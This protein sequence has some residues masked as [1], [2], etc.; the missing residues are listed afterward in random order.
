MVPQE[1]L[2]AILRS[3]HRTF[4]RRRMLEAMSLGAA[5]VLPSLLGALVLG[6]LTGPRRVTG[7]LVLAVAAVGIVL[8][9]VRAARYARRHHLSFGAFVLQIEER[10]GLRR[11]ELF[12]ALHLGRTASTL[13]DP[14]AREVAGEVL[15]IGS[16][17][18]QRIDYRVLARVRGVQRS[19]IQAGVALAAMLLL[20]ILAPTAVL[21]TADAALRPGGAALDRSAAIVVEPGDAT[22]ERGTDVLVKARLSGI[23]GRPVLYHRPVSGAWQRVEMQPTADGSVHQAQVRDLQAETEYAVGVD[24]VRSQ[25][26]RIRIEEPLRATGYE[27]RIQYPGYTGLSPEKELSPHGSIS[28][29]RGSKVDLLVSA[30]R[31]DAR[32]RL[33]FASGTEVALEREAEGVLRASFEVRSS[34][35]YRVELARASGGGAPWTSEAFNVDAIADRMPG[36]YLLSPGEQVD[37]PP[38]MRVVLEADCTDDFGIRRLDLAYRRNDGPWT[39]ETIDRWTNETEARSLHPWNL[40]GLAQV[41][42]DRIVYRLELTDNDAVTGPKTAITP[43]YVIRFPS[44]E[45]MYAEQHEERKEGIEDLR[46][47]LEEQVDLREQLQ[48]IAQDL[49]SDRSMQWEQSKEVEEFLRRQEEVVKKM[50]DLANSLDKQ[51]DRMQQGEMFSPE[52]LAKIAQIQDLVRQIQSPEFRSMMEKM[53]EAMASLDP[54]QIQKAMEEMKMTQKQLEQGLDRTLQMLQKMLAEEKLDEMIQR[55]ERLKEEQNSINN[56]LAKNEQGNRDSTA[57]MS[58]EEQAA[59]RERQ[60]AARK[61][62]EELRKQMEQLKEMAQK[63]HKEMAEALKSEQGQKSEENLQQASEQMDGGQQC[64]SKNNRRGAMRSGKKASQQMTQ[65]IQQMKEMQE[66]LDESKQA[67]LSRKMLGLAGDLV[68]MSKREEDVLAGASGSST[69][70]LAL[71]QNRI[72]RSTQ[73]VMDE[74][75]EA[76]RETPFITPGQMRAMA[77]AVASMEDATNAFEL[78]QRPGASALGAKAQATLDAVVASLLESNQSMCSSSASSSSCNNPKPGAMGQLQGL[79]QQQ[80]QLN[81]DTGQAMSEMQM[82]AGRLQQQGGASQ[83]LEQLAAR[84]MAIRQGLQELSQSMGEQNDMLGRLGDMGKEM[85]EIAKEMRDRNVDERILRRQEKILSRLLTAQ[86]SLRR[87]DFEEQRKSRTGVDAENPVSPPPVD[88]TAS[89]SDALRRG[90]LRGS[91]DQVPTDFRRLVE[92]YFRALMEK[93]Q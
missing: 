40:E 71:E 90:I 31:T 58:P 35:T 91:Q 9:V 28:V 75:Y 93:S 62:L 26:Y 48:Q 74:I 86:R 19:L 41:P 16:D 88:P 32:G 29:L 70:E 77:E 4:F 36:I 37:L 60:E 64:M 87:Q 7:V 56:D 79:S 22:V 53:R 2:L 8:G 49:R 10:A 76:A 67:E 47:T 13:P 52:I 11:N 69:R 18:A 3:G 66:Q 50:E 84:Q 59:A 33:R 1:R 51:L 68:E 82:G 14:F 39:R 57:S 25:Q 6:L 85:E 12:N 80:Q 78:G 30:S 44:L 45:E 27:K 81:Q 23:G 63:S 54:K 61:E 15:R 34:E 24:D 20:S 21:R 17:T 65:F 89:T 83:Q 42:G 73:S 92:Q 38:D 5:V 43:E 55:A 46:E 72:Q